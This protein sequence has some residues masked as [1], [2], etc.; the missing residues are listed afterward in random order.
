MGQILLSIVDAFI[1]RKGHFIVHNLEVQF[2]SVSLPKTETLIEH[3]GEN[4]CTICVIRVFN[5]L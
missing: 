5:I 2:A 3:E 1:N 4:L